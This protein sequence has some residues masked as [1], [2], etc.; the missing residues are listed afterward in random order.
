MSG[1]IRILASL[2]VLAICWV[3]SRA[4][5]PRDPLPVSARVDQEIDRRLA[6]AK[7]PASPLAD[8][9]EFLRRVCLDLTGQ[10]PS[11]DRAA[12]FLDSTDP[13]KRRKVIDELLDSPAAGARFAATWAELFLKRNDANQ[14][15]DPTAF[16]KWLANQFNQNA[17]WDQMVRAMITARGTDAA[18]LFLLTNAEKDIA[19]ARTTGT[20]GALFLGIQ[21]QCAE[22]HRHPAVKEWKREDFWALAAFFSRTRLDKEKGNANKGILDVEESPRVYVP[23]GD[24]KKPPPPPGDFLPPGIIEIPSATDPTRMVGQAKARFLEGAEADLPAEGPYRVLLADWV[25]GAENPWFT[26]A[27][28]NRVWA[29]FFSRGFVN[30]L[31][32]MTAENKPTHPAA[33]ELLQGEFVRSGFDLKHLMRCI[34]NTRAYQ[35]TSRA[36]PGNEN[37][38]VL[39]SHMA[40]KAIRGPVL[41]ALLEQVLG[42][43]PPEKAP[44][45]GNNSPRPKTTAM[46]LDTA[47]YDES[48]DEYTGGVPQALRLLNTVLPDRTAARATVLA[49]G[50][51]PCDKTV[52]T[53]YLTTLARRPRADEMREVKAFLDKQGDPVKGYAGL[54]WALLLSPEFVS[55][56]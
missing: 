17:G 9:A 32:N 26:A 13:D 14:R 43:S 1:A 39:F 4:G 10:L 19:P 51:D 55:N 49:R 35:R 36:L 56:H 12:A 40:V 21:L 7:I 16:R 28:V 41:L 38:Q 11:V 24:P 47:G 3:E 44:T 45:G 50:T 22:C 5:E 18:I 29:G 37:D 54:L 6:E 46:L 23:R 53:L 30:P 20:I 25:T 33:L 27:A 52:E 48:P 34:C 42:K 31:D 15:R 8:D 2:L